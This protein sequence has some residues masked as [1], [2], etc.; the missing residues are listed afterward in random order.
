MSAKH[1]V[2]AWLH[3]FLRYQPDATP[4]EAWD[5]LTYITAPWDQDG[6]IASVDRERRV[7][8]FRSAHGEP[9]RSMRFDAF[10][11]QVQRIRRTVRL[12]GR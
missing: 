2:S 3:Q 6:F 7:I 9:A 4:R 10:R 1:H 12:D 11:R 8:L 5:Y